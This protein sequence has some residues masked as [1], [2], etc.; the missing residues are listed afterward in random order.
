[1]EDKELGVDERRLPP[2]GGGEDWSAA[3]FMQTRPL[4]V[5]EVES[6]LTVC[7][8]MA[9]GRIGQVVVVPKDWR[10]SSRLEQPPEPMG[11]FTERDLIRA[12]A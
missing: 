1:M 4:A 8:R 2:S 10:P 9:E 11:I 5:T 6:V 7:E 12:F 3:A